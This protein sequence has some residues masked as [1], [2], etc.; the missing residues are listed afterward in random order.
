MCPFTLFINTLNC[1]YKQ[2]LRPDWAVHLICQMMSVCVE[3]EGSWKRQKGKSLLVETSSG[4]CPE[5]K[6]QA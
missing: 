5:G 4:V 3:K 1:F 2:P 6:G